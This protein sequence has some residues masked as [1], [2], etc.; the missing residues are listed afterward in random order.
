MKKSK[1][2]TRLEVGDEV[3][4]FD[5]RT[6]MEITKVVSVDK[7]TKSAKLENQIQV[8]RHTS[9]SVKIVPY[10]KYPL[11]IET[12]DVSTEAMKQIRHR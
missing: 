8:N 12:H 4:Y 10:H 3:I 11:L 2:E 1:L 7:E 6:L 9:V 5:G